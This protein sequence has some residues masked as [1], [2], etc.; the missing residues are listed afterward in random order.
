ML[1]QKSEFIKTY[2]IIHTA[3]G[4][5]ANWIKSWTNETIKKIIKM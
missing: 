3:I 4:I 5:M 1:L 2:Y